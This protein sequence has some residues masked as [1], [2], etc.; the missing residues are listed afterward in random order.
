MIENLNFNHLRTFMALAETLSFTK[1]A[2]RLKVSQPH[3][4]KQLQSLEE[5]LQIQ[6]VLRDQRRVSLTPQ[7]RRF[8]RDLKMHYESLIK[9]IEVVTGKSTMI[10]GEISVGSLVEIGQSTVIPLLFEFQK[11]NPEVEFNLVLESDPEIVSRLKKGALDFALVGSVPL[12]ENL[13]AYPLL[14]EKIVLVTRSQNLS[15]KPGDPQARFVAYKKGEGLL[16]AYVQAQTKIDRSFKPRVNFTV[17]SHRAMIDALKQ[18]DSFAVLPYRSVRSFVERGELR[19]EDYQA[20]NQLYLVHSDPQRWPVG[21]RDFRGW[22]VERFKN[23]PSNL[24]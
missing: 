12:L 24:E 14:S 1:A 2:E 3:V 9:S 6:L 21:K 19:L 15:I 7:G 11:I 8:F 4:S 16:K 17:N 5:T 13:R 23:L 20:Q 10:Q 18:A 22:I